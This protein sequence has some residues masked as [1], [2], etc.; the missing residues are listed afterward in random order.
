MWAFSISLILMFVATGVKVK[1]PALMV[2][3]GDFNEEMIH[4]RK[5]GQPEITINLKETHTDFAYHGG[6]DGRMVRQIRDYIMNDIKG[7]GITDLA[8]SIESHLMAI[9]TE[10]S[11]LQ[12]G[13]VIEIK[14]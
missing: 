13:K 7:D 12:N 3:E 11:R 8:S 4:V 1:K 14:H 9:A 2:A 10:E 6:G 5:F